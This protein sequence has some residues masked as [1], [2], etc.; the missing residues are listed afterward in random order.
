MKA[1]GAMGMRLSENM[2]P[3]SVANPEGFFEDAEIVE[4]HKQ[5]LVDLGSL[6]TL[7]LPEGWLE[8]EPAR[9]ARPRLRKV[10]E[11]RLSDANT[12]WGFKDPRT[13]TFLPLW[14]R[15]LNS[16]GTVP[17]YILAARAPASVASSLKRQIN[18]EEAIT[19]LQWLQR[20][21][22]ALHHTA[23]DCFI[24]HYEDWFTRPMEQAQELLRYTGLDQYFS[25]NAKEALKDVIKPNLNRAVYED[26]EVQN[27]YVLKLYDV[28]KDCRGADFDRQRLMAVVKECRKA[29]D[30]FKGWHLEAQ[31][32]ISRQAQQK[33]SKSVSELEKDLHNL[34]LQNNEYLKQLKDLHDEL[35][36]NRVRAVSLRQVQEE[37]QQEKQKVAKEQKH[38]AAMQERLEKSRNET[39][40]LKH[41][42]S[43]RLGHIIVQALTKPGK[44]TILAP[45]YLAVLARDIL[46]GRGKARAGEGIQKQQV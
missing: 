17:V 2:I 22:D 21:T 42:Y 38:V 29:M 4:I 18:R 9:K 16:P 34:T 14:N 31:R 36:E 45:Y 7:P 24:V 35:K 5:L 40:R 1:L 26:Y 46:T 32:R 28:L 19:E 10:L 3:A 20:T 11:S 33:N 25:G 37:L 39:L 6:P 13:V 8:A 41:S 43:F 23:A 15:I 27:E 44:N 12:I 30:G